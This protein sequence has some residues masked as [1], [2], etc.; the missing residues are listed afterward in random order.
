MNNKH[1]YLYGG[2]GNQM[3]QYAFYLSLKQ[4][5]IPCV[6]DISMYL[7]EKAHNGLELFDVFGIKEDYFKAPSWLGRGYLLYQKFFI[8]QRSIFP[9]KIFTYCPDVYNTDCMYYYGCWLSEDY[10]KSFSDKIRDIYHFKNIDEK[11]HESGLEMASDNTVSLH[12][13]RGD[14]LKFPRYYVCD[15]QYYKDAIEL[16]K[17]KV[18]NPLFFVFSDDTPWASQ[19]MERFKL[20]YKVID[21]NKGIR[22][23]QDMFLMSKCRHH[24]IA[25]STFSWWGAWLDPRPDKIVVAPST[26]FNIRQVRIDSDGW[27]IIN[28]DR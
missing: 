8:P 26:W 5:G 14:Y 27:N 10:F 2:L 21:F 22:S 6:L 12:V 20:K 7:V 9:E 19:M 15:E 1:V 16:I 18:E 23:Y 3:F 28:V 17:S 13:R 11:T 25:N 4:R 24:I